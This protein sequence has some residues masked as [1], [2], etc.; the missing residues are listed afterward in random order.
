MQDP[1]QV[2]QEVQR[3][4]QQAVETGRGCEAETQGRGQS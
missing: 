2:H 4:D 1:G 3:S